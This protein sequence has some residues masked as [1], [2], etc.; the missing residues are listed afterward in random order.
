MGKFP[1]NLRNFLFQPK[2]GLY[3][4]RHSPFACTFISLTLLTACD[5]WY[6]LPASPVQES[7]GNPSSFINIGEL[8]E[9]PKQLLKVAY[10]DAQDPDGDSLSFSM[11]MAAGGK[12]AQYGSAQAQRLFFLIDKELS[13]LLEGPFIDL[14]PYDYGS[15]DKD[16]YSTLDVLR[17]SGQVLINHSGRYRSLVGPY[18]WGVLVAGSNPSIPTNKSKKATLAFVN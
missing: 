12:N 17:E 9:S 6:S 5:F 1:V 11:A 4:R 18:T 15:F 10:V 13:D 8:I 2:N 3:F 7:T 14:L 16:L